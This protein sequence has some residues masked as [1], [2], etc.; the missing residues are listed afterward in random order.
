MHAVQEALAGLGVAV[1]V[2]LVFATT[3]AAGRIAGSASEVV[4]AV[5]GPATLQLHAREARGMPQ[6]L[7]SRVE[8]LRGVSQAAPLL[9]QR[10]S[11]IGPSGRSV[12]VDL[13]GA[14]A[15]LV[16]LDGLGHTLPRQTLSA[17]G[18]GLS[19][20]AAQALHIPAQAPPGSPQAGSPATTHV[21][22]QVD[23]RARRMKVSAVLGPEAFGALAKASVAVMP[24]AQLQQVSGL[25]QRISRVLVAA[26]P[27]QQAEVRAQ[28]LALADHRIDVA[29]AD[30][31][32]ALL[33]QALRPSDEANAFFATVAAVLG[34]LFALNAMLLTMPERRR[35]IAD[36][37][38]LG[39]K[40][41]AIVQMLLFQSLS[42]GAAASLLGLLGGYALSLHLLHQSPRYLIE[43]FT[44]GGGIALA[45]EPLLLSI[46][47]GLLA[48]FLASAVPLLDLRDDR[49][50]DA[51][52]RNGAAHRRGLTQ[53]TK[54]SLLSSSLLL[55]ALASVLYSLSPAQALLACLLLTLLAVATVPLT[56]SLIVA[57][58]ARIAR[59]RPKMTVLPL[60]LRSLRATTLRSLALA[61]TGAAA[62]FGSVAL[63]GA[64]SDLSRGIALFAAGYSSQAQIW[65]GVPGDNQAVVPF[66]EP[67][68]AGKI[69]KLPGVAGVQAFGGGFM[70]L[71]GRRVWVLARPS[72]AAYRVL[73]TQT[74]EGSPQRA[75]AML[76]RRGF[77][78]VS[79]QIAEATHAKLGGSIA[80][81]TPSGVRTFRVAAITTNLAW[82]P[83]AVLIGSAEYDRGWP[84]AGTTALGVQLRRGARATRVL[85]SIALLLAGSG[86]QAVSAAQRR[87]QIDSLTSEGLSQLHEISTLLMLAAILALAAALTSA[88]WQR[89]TAL[90]SLRLSGVKPS[91]LRLVLL[92]ESAL[93]LGAGCI[94]GALAGVYGEA[95]IDSHLSHVT[96]FPVASVGTSLWPLQ[97]F[98]LVGALV[99]LIALAPGWLACRVSPAF[100]FDG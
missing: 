48:A 66:S 75:A 53:A 8:R 6:S 57:A 76:S 83:G 79:R 85:H 7:L 81:P 91:R 74:L 100:A 22:V 46:A 61:A 55:L 78:A 20:A 26:K 27:H 41:G 40:R 19:L 12:Q 51:V 31:D 42:L 65:V 84:G 10:A 88:I 35:A 25:P 5:I 29:A 63:G 2:A 4:R 43:A 21:V 24:L 99:L 82:S 17:G 96:G 92:V 30:Q 95:V 73:R 54:R 50:V 1:A 9:E 37:R 13:A 47:V 87:A 11:I 93:I 15:A 94:T 34:L 89:R 80:L 69:A 44:L 71:R 14:D 59:H 39:V 16:V 49:A 86:L 23:G 45:L 72:S 58:A 68:L 62:L 64:R 28:L 56:F 38:L 52:H 70:E 97:A 60:A 67:A 18:V 33:R 98:A 32:L 90:A 77:V 36:L 3:V